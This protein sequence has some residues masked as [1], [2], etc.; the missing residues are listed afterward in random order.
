L[1]KGYFLVAEKPID[2]D[3]KF[4]LLRFRYTISKMTLRLRRY[5]WEPSEFIKEKIEIGKQHLNELFVYFNL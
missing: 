5:S 1:L 4:Q 2:F 3:E